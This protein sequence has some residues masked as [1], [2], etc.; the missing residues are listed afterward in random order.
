MS[1]EGEKVIG[2]EQEYILC[3]IMPKP[4]RQQRS[5]KT[6]TMMIKGTTVY[7]RLQ[8]TICRKAWMVKQT[9]TYMLLTYVHI[10]WTKSLARAGGQSFLEIP[11]A[12]VASVRRSRDGVASAESLPNR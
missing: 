9:S 11:E 6:S 4:V 3:C 2:Q 10:L 12:I 1:G 8:I 5:M 7:S